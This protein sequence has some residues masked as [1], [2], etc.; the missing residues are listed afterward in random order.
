MPTAFPWNRILPAALAAA[1]AGPAF[2]SGPSALQPEP[3]VLP[4]SKILRAQEARRPAHI[5]PDAERC[6]RGIPLPPGMSSLPDYHAFIGKGRGEYIIPITKNPQKHLQ[7]GDI[8][9]YPQQVDRESP[10][11]YEA[12]SLGQFHAAI[13]GKDPRSGRLFALHSPK[14]R[15][16]DLEAMVPFHIL[17]LN[18]GQEGRGKILKRVGKYVRLL[19]QDSSLYSNDSDRVTEPNIPGELPRLAAALQRGECP[20]GLSLYC[21]EL[22]ALV[23]GA[24]GV[25]PPGK[26]YSLLN[27]LPGVEA[28][29]RAAHAGL[30]PEAAAPYDRFVD[31][32]V[33]SLLQEAE[34]L[35]ELGFGNGVRSAADEAELAQAKALLK[36]LL[37]AKPEERAGIFRSKNLFSD[38]KGEIIGPAE[39]FLAP[40]VEGGNFSYAGTYIGR[41][42]APRRQESLDALDS[43]LPPAV[44]NA[45]EGDPF[46]GR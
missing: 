29:L 3:R 32:A 11:L 25:A 7:P 24:A 27:A 34:L 15:S 40:F 1:L 38:R 13:V 21:S 14:A 28:K 37:K 19:S 20:A 12:V 39:Y 35:K 9:V 42:C 31:Q 4:P 10:T 46:R 2:G 45:L 43:R 16:G 44:Q 26:T 6:Y 22:V 17:R 8:L 33:D 5:L 30:P 23:Y 36:E 18:P 41:G